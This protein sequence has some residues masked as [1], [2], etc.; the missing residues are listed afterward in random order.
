MKA[1]VLHEQGGPLSLEEMPAPQPGPG[2]VLV[3]VRACGLGL[4]LVWNRKGRGFARGD[5]ADKLPR[6]IGHE[7]AGDVAEVG[8]G[9]ISFKPGDRVNVY[10]YLTCGD[11]RWCNVGREDLCDN[12]AGYVGRQIDGGL[13]EYVKL[14][15]RNLC[16][17]PPEM[18]YVDAAVTADAISTPVHV[19]RERAQVRAPETVLVLGAGGG[20]GIHMVQMAKVLGARVIAVDISAEKLALAREMGADELIN[21][22]EVAFDEE[23]RRLTKGR[24]VDVV[25]EMVGKRETLE[26]SLR[27]LGKGGRLVFVGFYESGAELTFRPISLVGTEIILTGS[28]YCT[29]Q[30]LAEAVEL[31]AQGRIRPVV[32]RT[33]TLE[34]A[35]EV[36]Q[37]IERM[38][39]VGRACVVLP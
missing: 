14:P 24:G 19:L 31:V 13:A 34:E 39:T 22:R 32:T 36:L 28:K 26:A 23:A 1:L 11:C 9:V 20:V 10:F 12:F 2:E 33:C 21:A 30:Q 8:P 6:I 38:E 4:T 29:R 35:D 5:A 15:V 18:G 3:R 25:V 16:H 27:S 7:I 17:I 37:S